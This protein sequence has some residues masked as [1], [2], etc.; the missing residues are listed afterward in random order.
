MHLLDNLRDTL[1]YRSP[2]N[3]P[4]LVAISV[5]DP[6]MKTKIARSLKTELNAYSYLVGFLIYKYLAN[7]EDD[8]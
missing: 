6:F 2:E 8:H 3:I 7:K 1:I 4:K 5:F